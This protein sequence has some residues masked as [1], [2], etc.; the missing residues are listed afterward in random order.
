V[1]SKA[2]PVKMATTKPPVA[3]PAAPKVSEPKTVPVAPPAPKNPAP[4]TG[5]WRIQLGA[6]SQLGA[7]EA[8]FQRVSGRAALAGRSP[9]YIV[10]GN[11]TRLQVGPFASKAA[12]SAA[13]S[14]IGVPCFAVPAK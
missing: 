9:Y 11:V 4:P 1:P 7:A 2:K 14:S 13:C 10:A 8:L 3:K 12:A 6:F 5:G